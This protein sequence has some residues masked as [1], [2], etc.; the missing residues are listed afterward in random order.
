MM[1]SLD[2]D[3]VMLPLIQS[4]CFPPRKAAV[5]EFDLLKSFAIVIAAW[6]LDCFLLGA[7]MTMSGYDASEITYEKDT[8]KLEKRP[9]SPH[10]NQLWSRDQ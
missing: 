2:I 3:D 4:F 5:V 6:S 9:S 7:A 10:A 8:L 1:E